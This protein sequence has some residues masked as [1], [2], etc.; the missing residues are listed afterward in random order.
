MYDEPVA[1]ALRALRLE[2]KTSNKLKLAD[3]LEDHDFTDEA[4]AIFRECARD[5]GVVLT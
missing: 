3:W 1:N 5:L 4:E 2:I